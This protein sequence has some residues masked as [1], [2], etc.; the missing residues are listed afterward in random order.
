MNTER[1]AE[2]LGPELIFIA[3][4]ENQTV[5]MFDGI[6]IRM[7]Q[8]GQVVAAGVIA[9]ER[10]ALTFTKMTEIPDIMIYQTI[11]LYLSHYPSTLL[12]V[13]RQ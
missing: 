9:Q 4:E 3:L 12:T 6:E 8:H 2:Q 5:H 10:L 13:L 1:L 11:Y 7:V